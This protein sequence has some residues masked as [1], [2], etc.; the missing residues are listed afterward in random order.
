MSIRVMSHVW[1]HSQAKGSELLLL[2]A[3][4]D[5]ADDEGAAY[6]AVKTLAGK[7]RMSIRAVNYLLKK[8]IEDGELAVEAGGGRGHANVYR[9]QTLQSLQRKKPA[10]IAEKAPK[11][12]KVFT[13]KSDANP[14]IHDHAGSTGEPSS[15]PSKKRSLSPVGDRTPPEPNQAYQL[16][17]AYCEGIDID[18]SV[19]PRKAKSRLMGDLK[20]LHPTY[21]PDQ[22]KRCASWLRSD[23]FWAD[24]L[25]TGTGITRRIPYWVQAG[26]PEVYVNG[27]G[28]NGTYSAG[29]DLTQFRGRLP[30]DVA[31][32]I[33]A[34][35]I[36]PVLP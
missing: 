3:I 29:D 9:V 24:K 7:V 6:P 22:V 19:V 33:R 18:P 2:L 17:E 14:A 10:K 4:A 25:D 31:A 23:P 1:Q 34:G 8:L 27:K 13:E 5:F 35:R 20:D 12:C 21:S 32:R 26:E 16:F 11:P 30:P 15:E 28:K 36:G